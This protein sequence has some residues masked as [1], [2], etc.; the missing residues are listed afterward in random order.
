MPWN[1]EEINDFLLI[2]R[3]KDAKSVK[4][5]KNRDDMKFKVC[6]SRYLYTLVI[7]DKEMAEKL[8]QSPA[9]RSGSEGA[10]MNQI[11]RT[12][13]KYRKRKE[14]KKK[15]PSKSSSCSTPIRKL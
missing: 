4:I 7:T 13:L 12:V 10:E 9:P 8:K 15:T 6:C 11:H 5:K 3:R 14:K 2:A 1:I